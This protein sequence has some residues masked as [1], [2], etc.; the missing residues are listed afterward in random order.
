[1]NTCYRVLTTALL[2]C[3]TCFPDPFLKALSAENRWPADR[4][5]RWYAS[6]TWLCGTKFIPSTSN[7]QLEKRQ[8]ETF[9]P[10]TIDS[11][12]SNS[13]SISM[14]TMR[15]FLHDL[16]WREDQQGFYARVD[17]YLEIADKHRIKT[18]FV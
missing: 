13:K 15:M 10:D 9:D 14:N 1:M 11:E 16:A 12:L 2:L 8:K 6:Q 17:K 4:A 3:G 7:N 5:Q 18:L